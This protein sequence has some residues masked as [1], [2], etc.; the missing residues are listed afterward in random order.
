MS[1]AMLNVQN[2]SPTARK[3]L[4]LTQDVIVVGL[5]VMLFFAMGVK[6]LH[7]GQSMVAGR[8]FSLF[9]ADILFISCY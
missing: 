2:T 9:V 6:L 8:D 4:E 1:A 7:L 3:Y 5:C